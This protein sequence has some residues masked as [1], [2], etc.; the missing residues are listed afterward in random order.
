MFGWIILLI[1]VIIASVLIASVALPRLYLKKKYELT[2]SEDRGIKKVLE[3]NGQSIVYE[4][5]L[6]WRKYVKQYVLSER[7]GKKQLICKIDPELSYLAYD[8]AVFNHKD[9]LV[10]VL[11]VKER[12]EGKEFTKIVE[13]PFETSYVALTVTEAD[14]K[15]FSVPVSGKVSAGNVAKY[16]FWST[17]CLIMATLCIKVCFANIF[18][19]IF[20]ESIVLDE[21]GIWITAIILAVLIFINFLTC[22]IT[23]KVNGKKSGWKK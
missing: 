22:L 11:N 17:L 10:T 12:V 14:A 9:E 8:I 1:V 18:G 13:L 21:D 4:P 6:Q 19:G 16:L 3:K 15:S 5:A 2:E 20:R 7:R 23:V